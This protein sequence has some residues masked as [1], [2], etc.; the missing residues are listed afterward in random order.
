[1]VNEK[2][3]FCYCIGKWRFRFKQNYLWTD[4]KTGKVH[5]NKRFS[6]ERIDDKDA[7][8]WYKYWLNFYTGFH[9]PCCVYDTVEYEDNRH[10]MRISIGWGIL[11]IYFPWRNKK[12]NEEDVNNPEPKY[13]FYFYGEGKIPD[14]LVYYRNKNGHNES[15]SIELPWSYKFYRHSIYLDDGSWWTMLDKERMKARKKEKI[16]FTD[17]RFYLPE[18]SELI[19]KEKHPFTYV[20][21]SG[22]VQKTTATCFIEEREWRRKWLK[23]TKL[24]NLVRTTVS[25][26]FD[27]EMGNE[28]GSWK[29][30]V[31]G[32]SAPMTKEEKENKDIVGALR[33]Y[34]AEVNR[35]H[36]YC[37]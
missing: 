2:E 19:Y 1:M 35:I 5:M 22:E 36:D 6:I 34:E 13:G 24:Y 26:S 30:G 3:Y 25:I 7:D 23:W 37:G 14:T 12:V 4:K 10:N 18:D 9:H 11:Y 33:R 31:L 21:K 32:V 29:G 27:D 28:R 20:T 17:P 15:H 8:G 16:K